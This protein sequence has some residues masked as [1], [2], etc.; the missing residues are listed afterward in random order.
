MSNFVNACFLLLAIPNIAAPE[1]I[2]RPALAVSAEMSDSS[3]AQGEPLFV[4]LKVTRELDSIAQPATVYITSLYDGVSLGIQDSSGRVLPTLPKPPWSSGFTAFLV[5]KE[6]GYGD[7]FEKTLIAHQWISTS[8][9]PGSYELI[10]ELRTL[11]YRV[12][13]AK[14]ENYVSAD[15]PIRV[16]VP[17]TILEAD[18][19][20]VSRCYTKL[21]D[22]ITDTSRSPSSRMMAFDAII[23]AHGASALPFQLDLVERMYGDFDFVPY[24][25]KDLFTMFWSIS[26]MRDVEN[27]QTIIDFLQRPVITEVLEGTREDLAGAG[28]ILKWLVHELHRNGS[29]RIQEMTKEFAEKIEPPVG[30]IESVFVEGGIRVSRDY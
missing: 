2:G 1:E 3:I 30:A 20:R 29:E 5:S 11:D 28:I 6:L 27:A 17:V 24:D 4:M 7:S 21:L 25:Q 26:Q 12:D 19:E 15:S 9:P 23:L 22:T 8:L 16:I 13:S 10:V 14:R 18:T